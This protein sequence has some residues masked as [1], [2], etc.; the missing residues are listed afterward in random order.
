[1]KVVP[2]LR[3]SSNAFFR[4]EG[5]TDSVGRADA[6]QALSQRRADA[7][8]NYLVSKGFSA[9]RLIAIGNG[10]S[11]PVAD[12]STDGGRS[13]NRRTDIKVIANK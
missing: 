7:V 9:E 10:S 5:N 2:L 1:A 12:N 11:K 4:I 6:N 3:T 13:A 8:V